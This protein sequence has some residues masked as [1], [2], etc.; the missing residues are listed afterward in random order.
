MVFEKLREMI[1]EQLK[2]AEDVVTLGTLVL[3]DLGADSLDMVDLAMSIEESFDVVIDD[4]DIEGLKTVGDI[5]AY[6]EKN[7]K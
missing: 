7:Q 4:N 3:D 2:I 6:I 1:C 5:V